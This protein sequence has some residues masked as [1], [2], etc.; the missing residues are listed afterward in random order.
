MRSLEIASS[1]VIEA[2]NEMRFLVLLFRQTLTVS[3][4]LCLILPEHE[5]QGS[6]T[7]VLAYIAYLERR[8]RGGREELHEGSTSR[9][10][11][12]HKDKCKRF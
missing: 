8:T 9:L 7:F 2:L 10:L 6:P 3:P 1:Y 4:R 5:L 11:P 12:L